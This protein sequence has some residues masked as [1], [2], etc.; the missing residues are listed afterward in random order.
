[1]LNGD[2]KIIYPLLFQ[3]LDRLEDYKTKVYLA[4]YLVEI[5]VPNEMLAYDDMAETYQQYK[6]SLEQFKQTHQA[7]HELKQS[8]T[9]PAILKAEIMDQEKDREQLT[10]K[11]DEL[12]KKIKDMTV[13]ISCYYSTSAD[14]LTFFVFRMSQ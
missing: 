2:R 5:K 9:D 6:Q 11:I 14:I 1:M 7:L 10:V 13:C 8:V 4:K 12:K 3:I